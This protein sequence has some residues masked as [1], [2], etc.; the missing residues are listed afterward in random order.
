MITNSQCFGS[1]PAGG[2]LASQTGRRAHVDLADLEPSPTICDDCYGQIVRRDDGELV[3]VDGDAEC[4]VAI[5]GQHTAA[6]CLDDHDGVNCRGLVEL[7]CAPG[8]RSWPRCRRHAELRWQRYENSIERYADCEVVPDWF[9]PT[10][11]GER[12]GEPK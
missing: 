6:H 3:S 5:D 8:G 4:R 10:Y 1:V 9:D 2:Q 12:C 11:A 7:R